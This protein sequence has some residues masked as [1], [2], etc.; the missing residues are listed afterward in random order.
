M[1]TRRGNLTDSRAAPDWGV[2][3]EGDA[4]LPVDV[5]GWGRDAVASPSGLP[6]MWI[7]LTSV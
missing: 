5:H 1:P 4:A 7:R 2:P 3:V 6:D